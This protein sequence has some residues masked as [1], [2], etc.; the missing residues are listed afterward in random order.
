[1]MKAIDNVCAAVCVL[2][3]ARIGDVSFEV[4]F[5]ASAWLGVGLFNDIVENWKKARRRNLPIW[6]IRD[7]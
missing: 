3:L 5:M 6:R 2:W 7:E 1:M 4:V